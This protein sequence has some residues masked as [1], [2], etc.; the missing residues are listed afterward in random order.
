MPDR[1]PTMRD[2]IGFMVMVVGMFMAIL[3]IQIVS[4]SLSEIQAGLA[5]SSDEATWIQTSYLIAEV[6]SIPLSGLL[7]RLLSTRVL[8][9]LSAA[10][11]TLASALCAMA[12]DINSMIVFR[13]L[14]GFIGGAMIPTVF[15]TAY[16]FFPPSKRNML[17]VLM[18]LIATMAP[19]LGP[20]IGGYITEISSW[21]WLFLANLAPGIL[22][23]G[24]VWL[25]VDVDRPDW[26]LLPGLDYLGLL[27]MA[28]FL[29][30]L[31]FVL[32][33]GPRDDWFEDHL[34]QIFAVVSAIGGLLFVWRVLTYRQPIVDIRA[35]ANRNFLI[36]CSFSFVIGIGLYG[37]TYLLPLYLSHIRNY[38]ALDIGVVMIVTGA[39]QFMSAP[40]AGRLANHLDPRAMLA[41]GLGLF[42]LGAYLQSL[43]TAEWGFWEFFL[44]QACRGFALMFLF[45]PINAAALGTLPAERVKNASGL[46][47]LMRNLGGA[48]GLAAINS[49]LNDRF[50]L[51]WKRLVESLPAGN[52]NVE[53]FLDQA[54]H[55]MQGAMGGQSAAGAVRMLG[56]LVHREAQVMTMADVQFL[57]GLLFVSGIFLVPLLRRPRGAVA[58]DH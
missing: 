18:G 52:P 14:Q 2:W 36:G 49:V 53:A 12:W 28:V 25:L 43:L 10:G 7:A 16:S 27:F 21:H 47:N 35:F 58:A 4:S 17:S 1:A 26:S 32:E 8:F 40:V 9:S 48:V 54:Q 38:S 5:A 31:E 33:E 50:A 37:S 45:I 15:A 46:Y 41:F 19:T 57:M 29:G 42:G 24:A 11:F 3:D 20:T 55:G 6:I 34:I 51:H 44:P 39:F 13:A 22:V 56:D 30:S 23:A